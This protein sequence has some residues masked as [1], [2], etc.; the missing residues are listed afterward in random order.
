MTDDYT[1][2]LEANLQTVTQWYLDMFDRMEALA[3][4][5]EAGG[6]HP[7]AARIRAA[8]HDDEEPE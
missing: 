5:A 6:D 3:A 7:T 2:T 8:L 1:V 4:E